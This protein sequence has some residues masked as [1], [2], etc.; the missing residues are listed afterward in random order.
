[1][2]KLYFQTNLILNVRLDKTYKKNYFE[3]ELIII[4]LIIR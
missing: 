3:L 2:F 1:M 4:G